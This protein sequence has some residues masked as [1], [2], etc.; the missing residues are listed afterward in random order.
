MGGV[1]PRGESDGRQHN[2]ADGGRRGAA[3][4][5][6]ERA[7]GSHFVRQL[8]DDQPPRRVAIGPRQGRLEST[9]TQHRHTV[10]DRI[11]EHLDRLPGL[12]VL[13]AGDLFKTRAARRKFQRKISPIATLDMATRNAYQ[14]ARTVEQ[15]LAS[16]IGQER[17]Q[18]NNPKVYETA[19]VAAIKHAQDALGSPRD[20]DIARAGRNIPGAQSG[21]LRAVVD[22]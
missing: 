9:R 2:E 7:S 5:D 22:R 14:R 4:F 20:I 10:A 11:A 3:H 21:E 12:G 13:E 8:C 15:Q 1:E 6:L 19:G 18:K 16:E 17:D